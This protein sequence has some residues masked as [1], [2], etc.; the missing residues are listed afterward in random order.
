MEFKRPSRVTFGNASK[1]E[2]EKHTEH[3]D[4]LKFNSSEGSFLLLSEIAASA[5]GFLAMTD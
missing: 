4:S 2:F 1:E 3:F 5:C